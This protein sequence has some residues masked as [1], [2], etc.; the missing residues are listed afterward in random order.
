MPYLTLLVGAPASGKSTHADRHRKAGRQVLSSDALRG[1]IGKNESDQSV[2]GEVFK[3]MEAMTGYFLSRGEDVTI[4]ATNMTKAAR[5]PFIR[6]GRKYHAYI[7]AIVFNTP[8]S[9]CKE[10]NAA[11]ERK[12]PEDV[13]DRMFARYERPDETEVHSLTSASGYGSK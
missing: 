12:V 1:V 9:V 3:I 2:S 5:A 4:D 6:M 7:V 13:I 10:R 8:A 11:R